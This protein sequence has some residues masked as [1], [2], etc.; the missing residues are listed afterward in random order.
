MG[1]GRIIKG[2]GGVYIVDT[3]DRHVTCRACGRFRNDG[4][5]PL[6]G[7]LV[8]FLPLKDGRGYMNAILPRKNYLIR[9]PIA[10]IDQLIIVC[11]KAPPETSTITIDRLCAL[12][13]IMDIEVIICVNKVDLDPAEEL[14]AIYEKAGIITVRFSAETGEGID[15]LKALLEGKI[16][17]LTGNSGVGKSSILNLLDIGFAAEVGAISKRIGQGRQ[18]TRHTEL[19]RFGTGYVAD[20]PGFSAFSLVYAEMYEKDNLPFGFIE[21]LPYLTGC[22]FNNCSHTGEQ[23][24]VI[25]RA[26]AEGHIGA[27][28]YENYKKLVYELK[29]IKQWEVKKPR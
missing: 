10:N 23:G 1:T 16:S 20:T 25:E 26:V 7:D 29:D 14:A 9:P 6:S 28:R 3:G 22:R 21:F 15:E 19:V 17:V 4:E 13:T 8:E 5:T 2:V 12:A 18:T 27:E 11:S 24:C